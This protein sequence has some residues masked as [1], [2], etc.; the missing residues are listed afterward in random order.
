MIVSPKKLAANR[1]NAQISTGPKTLRGKDRSKM[2][3]IKH[4]AYA[5]ST[6]I[7]GEDEN[8]YRA[9]RREQV[10]IYRP[11]TYIKKALVDQLVDKMWMLKRVTMAERLHFKRGQSRLMKKEPLK[12]NSNEI[13]LLKMV[14]D[15]PDVIMQRIRSHDIDEIERE[16][17]Q[18][19]KITDE[20]N[21]T[22]VNVEDLAWVVRKFGRADEVY[23]DV[24]LD[25]ANE[26]TVERL[27]SLM[28]QLTN[29]ILKLE[30]NCAGD[31]ATA[32]TAHRAQTTTE[33]SWSAMLERRR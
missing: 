26:K 14:R 31:I 20:K 27:V 10:K 15:C 2:N 16:P 33:T 18:V 22:F 1:S 12:F 19:T 23:A 17:N 13:R 28:R 6:F 29:D 21:E 8:L 30:L 5:T 24:L 3:A 11:E 7:W 25:P 32:H 4:G 9:I